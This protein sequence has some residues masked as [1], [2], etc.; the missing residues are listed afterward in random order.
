MCSVVL[1]VKK[2]YLKR[3]YLQH[4]I[5]KTS[6]MFDNQKSLISYCDGKSAKKW[7]KINMKEKLKSEVEKE[8]KKL[9]S[10]YKAPLKAWNYYWPNSLGI[11][12]KG[13]DFEKMQKHMLQPRKNVFVCGDSFSLHQCWMEGAIL[14]A[15]EIVNMSKN[16]KSN[17][18]VKHVK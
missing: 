9:D 17:K 10:N 3:N 14:T 1:K 4:C 16:K 15:K 18:T 13:I 6:V 11:W 12:K 8:V 5:L 7:F 2:H